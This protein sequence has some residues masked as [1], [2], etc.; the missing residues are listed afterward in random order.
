MS[1]TN[2]QLVQDFGIVVLE[3]LQSESVLNEIAVTKEDIK[4]RHEQTRIILTRWVD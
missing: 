2:I 4:E 3:M 1:N